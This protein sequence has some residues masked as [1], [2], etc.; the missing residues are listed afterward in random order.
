MKKKSRI[1]TAVILVITMV[2]CTASVY[3]SVNS[4]NKEKNKKQQQLDAGRAYEVKLARQIKKLQAQISSDQDKIRAL[5]SQIKSGEKKVT[6]LTA[7]MEK[8]KNRVDKGQTELGGRLR[9][10]YK[11]GSVGF[12]DVIFSAG[13]VEEILSNIEMVK[14]IYRSD[15]D[16]VAAL[17]KKYD[18]I[19]A[20]KEHIEKLQAGMKSKRAEVTK[21]QDSL[22]S[23]KNKIKRKKLEIAEKNEKL[24]IE[25]D[26]L[27]AQADA[28]TDKIRNYGSG[29]SY[30]GGRMMWPTASTYVTSPFG[31]RI[32][33][34]HGRE[35]HTGIDISASTGSRIVAASKG[36][37][38]SA[39][40]NGGYGNCVIISHGGGIVTLYA[41]NSS[42]VVSV[43]QHVRRGQQIARAGSTGNSTGP[44]CHFEVR[45]N[46]GYVNPMN[47]LR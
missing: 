35:F 36:T 19:K 38:M 29:G 18:Q 32:C 40:W 8:Q 14:E 20:D 27:Q 13:N 2:C 16:M 37:V 23:A 39:G 26:N 12:I 15:R 4:I 30:T 34:F 25:V 22:V 46:G 7:R 45:V 28:L 6:L 11:S 43:G 3:G 5:N 44:H 47:Y 10:M 24:E 31:Y 33:P 21:K 17:Q 1:I 42:I 41:H 9:N